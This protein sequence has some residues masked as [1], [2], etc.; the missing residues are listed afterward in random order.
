MV[1]L[2]PVEVSHPEWTKLRQQYNVPVSATV[3][4]MSATDSS[5]LK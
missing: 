4:M 3:F 5:A 1:R 2:A